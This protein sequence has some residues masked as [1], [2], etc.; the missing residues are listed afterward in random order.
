M[1]AARGER[2]AVA[3]CS[4]PPPSTRPA[5]HPDD[6]AEEVP[7]LVQLLGGNGVTG[8]AVRTCLNSADTGALRRLHPVLAGVLAGVPFADMRT[9]V[10]D[11]VRWRAALPA[12]VSAQLVKEIVPVPAVGAALLGLTSLDLTRCYSVGDSVVAC[13]P[14]SLRYGLGCRPAT[15]RAW[16]T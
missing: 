13:L 11:V 3:R 2:G 10:R 8:A 16:C 4:A 1:A 7:L 12:A 9:G 5:A 14:S 15:H 6:S